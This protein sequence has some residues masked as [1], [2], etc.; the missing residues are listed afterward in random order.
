MSGIRIKH[1]EVE[2]IQQKHIEEII[3][4]GRVRNKDKYNQLEKLHLLLN[5]CAIDWSFEK[6]AGKAQLDTVAH[7]WKISWTT[8]MC[9]IALNVILNLTLIETDLKLRNRK[10]NREL[11]ESSLAIENCA[12]VI[13]NWYNTRRHKEE[14][15]LQMLDIN[16]QER[17][18]RV[19]DLIL[20]KEADHW[21]THQKNLRG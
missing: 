18:K 16:S 6:G 1:L 5:N 10:P 21:E 15:L 9:Q 4:K 12:R 14:V 7:V 20:I 11:S 2:K 13:A 3:Q 17:I 8:G 19:Q